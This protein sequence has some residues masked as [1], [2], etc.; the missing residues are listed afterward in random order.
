MELPRKRGGGF[1][2]AVGDYAVG[3]GYFK[4]RKKRGRKKKS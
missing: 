4:K 1:G 2:F 3:V